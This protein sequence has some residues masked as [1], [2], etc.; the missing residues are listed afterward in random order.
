MFFSKGHFF[1][2]FL[3][4]ILIKIQRTKDLGGMATATKTQLDRLSSPS[5]KISEL[6]GLIAL[7]FIVGRALSATS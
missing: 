2:G 6:G 1:L 7:G 4:M 5:F 3:A